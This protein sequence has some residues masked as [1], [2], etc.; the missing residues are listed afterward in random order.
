MEYDIPLRDTSEFFSDAYYSSLFTH[1]DINLEDDCLDDSI[2]DSFATQILDAKYE[3]VN[4]HD[5]AFNQQHLSL[6][7]RRDLFH[8]L[9]KHEKLF[10]GSL[11]VYPHKQVH[12]ELKPGAKPVHHRAYPVPHVHRQ[13]F[14]KELDHMVELGILEPCGASE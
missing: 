2:V 8:I 1:L 4:I 12:I 13:T 10:D 3:Q 7:Q 5:V 6:D 9:S 11:G 14:K